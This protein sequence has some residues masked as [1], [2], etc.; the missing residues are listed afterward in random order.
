[1][2]FADGRIIEDNVC[3]TR[4]TAADFLR[5]LLRAVQDTYNVNDLAGDLVD[6]DVRKRRKYEFARPLF[7]TRTPAGWERQQRGG[8]RCKFRGPVPLLAPARSEINNQ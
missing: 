8:G 7:L 2:P 4:E 6:H 1:M 5:P 3:S